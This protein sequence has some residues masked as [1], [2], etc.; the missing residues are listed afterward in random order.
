M[1]D[2][3]PGLFGN[4]AAKLRIGLAIENKTLAHAFLICGPEGS[5]KTTLALE[6]AAAVNCENKNDPR[7]SLPCHSCNTCRRIR[8]GGFV[9]IKF[10]ER[11][12]D[13]QT[14]GVSEIRDYREDM[15]LSSS[16][17]DHKIY[18]IKDADKM[19][20]NAQMRF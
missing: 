3:L 11:K 4:D 12:G 2:F 17:S 9:D 8:S 19:T 6:M 7:H 20:P 18:I 16:E 13:K 10:L 15:F 5:G 14:I 1:R